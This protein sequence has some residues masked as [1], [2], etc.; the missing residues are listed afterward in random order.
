MCFF[1]TFGFSVGGARGI[2]SISLCGEEVLD[3]GEEAGVVRLPAGGSE[4]GIRDGLV[5]P[6]AFRVGIGG[7]DRGE[8]LVELLAELLV[9]R[10]LA[11]RLVVADVVES[12]LSF[13]HQVENG[14]GG[15]VAVDLVQDS[16][17]KAVLGFFEG[18]FL[19]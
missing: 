7:S 11:G 15:V 8:R 2:C 4:F 14:A 6:T 1:E 18:G 12:G 5:S 9:G 17:A 3:G 10:E 19:C 13:G 16:D